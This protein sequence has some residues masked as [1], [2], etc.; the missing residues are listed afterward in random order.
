MPSSFP[1]PRHKNNFFHIFSGVSIFE[2]LEIQP[3]K[4]IEFQ[5][6]PFHHRQFS[7]IDILALQIIWR[8]DILSLWKFQHGDILVPWTLLQSTG[9][10]QHKHILEPLIFWC[11]NFGTG[12]IPHW[13]IM[14]YQE[15]I[16][17]TLSGPLYIVLPH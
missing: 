5:Q 7:T 12:T 16:S 9:T 14:P 4:R 17:V 11:W 15:T 3:L 1:L 2:S 13:D 8:M 10:F 6:D